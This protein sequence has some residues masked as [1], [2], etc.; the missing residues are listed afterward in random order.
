MGQVAE[1]LE[2]F[3]DRPGHG[4]VRPRAVMP[5]EDYEAA[6]AATAPDWH[7]EEP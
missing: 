4:V 3:P 1:N 7:I 5:L 6:L 2:L